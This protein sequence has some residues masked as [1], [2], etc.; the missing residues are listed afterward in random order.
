VQ[1]YCGSAPCWHSWPN[2]SGS[3]SLKAG[4]RTLVARLAAAATHEIL[5]IDTESGG[6]A[7]KN[8]QA[9]IATRPL[10]VAEVALV[11]PGMGGQLLLRKRTR[12]SQILNVQPDPFLQFLVAVLFASLT[13]TPAQAGA[14][15]Q[16]AEIRHKAETLTN[17]CE[18]ALREGL[19][20]MR[21][22]PRIADLKS[23]VAFA[24]AP[25]GSRSSWSG[26]IIQSHARQN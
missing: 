18:L 15:D 17:N 8:Q 6:N 10:D 1:F 12:P 11:D 23:L 2:R 5:D 14:A 21:P 22:T 9:R 25:V 13:G 3:V 4:R 20:K 16:F 7:F 19:G 26:L 24:P